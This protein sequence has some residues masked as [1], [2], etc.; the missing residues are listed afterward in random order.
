M[1]RLPANTAEGSHVLSTHGAYY[2]NTEM[3]SFNLSDVVRAAQAKGMTEIHLIDI[4]CGVFFELRDKAY[5]QVK[6]S[7]KLIEQW[8]KFNWVETNLS[9]KLHHPNHC[10][11]T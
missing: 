2:V 4:S 3:Y 8:I 7:P 11:P 10:F 9:G 1:N 5:H 6:G